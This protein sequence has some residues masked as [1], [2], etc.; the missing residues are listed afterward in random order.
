ML[1]VGRAPES[2]LPMC[3]VSGT[4][5]KFAKA[6]DGPLSCAKRD[7]GAKWIQLQVGSGNGGWGP[8]TP[9]SGGSA[10]A[11]CSVLVGLRTSLPK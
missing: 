5:A 3:F 8:S 7:A 11:R 2:K 10:G 1:T 4:E 6:S 9:G